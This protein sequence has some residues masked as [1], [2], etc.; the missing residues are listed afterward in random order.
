MLK[1]NSQNPP[2]VPAPGPGGETRIPM[3]KAG[4]TS[5]AA[6]EAFEDS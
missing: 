2:G 1:Q 5:S 3:E 4:A 6:R